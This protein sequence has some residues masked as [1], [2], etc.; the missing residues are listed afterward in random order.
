[1]RKSI[2]GTISA[3]LIMGSV[4]CSRIE[5]GE[6]GLRVGFDKQVSGVELQPGSFNQTLVGDV[7]TFPVRDIAVNVENKTPLT[8]DNSSLKD[9]DFQ[10]IYQVNPTSVSELWTKQSRQFH[11]YDGGDW[12][13]MANALHTAAN[14]AAQKEVRKYEALLV[15][16]NRAKIEKDTIEG[17]TDWLKSQGLETAIKVTSMQIK[18]AVPSDQIVA[19]ANQVVKAR[20]ELAAKTIEVQTAKQ[21]AERI[22][23]LNANTK[24]IEYMQAQ[25]QQDIAKGIAAGKVNT[26]VVPYDFKGIV[27]V[28]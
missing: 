24:A 27:S 22:A 6:V 13:L 17:V 12:L 15:N 21:E 2:I 10:I 7:L 5:S 1:M 25:A 18:S 8:A 19:A 20:T 9:F 14:N 26:I 28:K 4:G 16:D 3:A 11:F 23:A